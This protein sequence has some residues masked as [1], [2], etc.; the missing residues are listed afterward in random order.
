MA[1]EMGSSRT[2]P[3][4]AGS[5]RVLRTSLIL[6]KAVVWFVYVMAVF[7]IVVIAFR[8]VLLLLGANPD[9][10]FAEFIYRTSGDFMQPFRALFPVKPVGQV[11]YVDA[12]ALFAIA[13]YGFF[14][15]A[16]SLAVGWFDHRLGNVGGTSRQ[17]AR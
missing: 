16:V 9:A 3:T 11:G 10:A 5:R 2:E 13:A 17:A 4:D 7:A 15:W 12:S 1:G 6:G 8:F 14:A